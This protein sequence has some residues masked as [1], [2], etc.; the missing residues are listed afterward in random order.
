MLNIHY[1]FWEQ[2]NPL[3]SCL[4]SRVRKWCAVLNKTQQKQLESGQKGQ[5]IALGQCSIWLKQ[6]VIDISTSD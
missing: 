3:S 2:G 6:K 1:I 4:I 5:D